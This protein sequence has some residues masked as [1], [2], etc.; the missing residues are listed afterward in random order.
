MCQSPKVCKG[1]IT[2][3]YT[4][5]VSYFIYLKIYFIFYYLFMRTNL[6]IH[7]VI[8]KSLDHRKSKGIPEKCLF[9]L[10]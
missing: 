8:E 10:H 7:W 6:M 1:E 3:E 2:P 4:P 5:S 9:L